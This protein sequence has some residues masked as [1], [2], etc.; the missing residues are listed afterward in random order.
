[1]ADLAAIIKAWGEMGEKKSGGL[2]NVS[3][4]GSNNQNPTPSP[5]LPGAYSG[6]HS[7]AFSY[8]P[9]PLPGANPYSYPNSYTPPP[10]AYAN[11]SNHW[12]YPPPQQAYGHTPSYGHPPPQQ[13]HGKP[14]TDNYQSFETY[15]PPPPQQS[16]GY[17][18]SY[19][20]Q[21]PQQQWNVHGYPP[22]VSMGGNLGASAPNQGGYVRSHDY[23]ESHKDKGLQ[24]GAVAAATG[25]AHMDKGSQAGGAAAAAAGPQVDTQMNTGSQA[26]ATAAASAAVTTR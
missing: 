18:L 11:A 24:G 4:L 13:W 3:N 10:Y 17:H 25:G 2:F 19:G 5:Y 9:A 12:P 20:A 16:H 23:D 15:S 21:P 8:N 1:M 14:G 6:A 7:Y 22:Q 26:G